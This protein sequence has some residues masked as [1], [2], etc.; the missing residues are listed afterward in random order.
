MLQLHLKV[1]KSTKYLIIIIAINATAIFSFHH[2]IIIS[3]RASPATPKSIIC[4]S[5]LTHHRFQLQARNKPKEEHQMNINYDQNPPVMDSLSLHDVSSNLAEMNQDQKNDEDDDSVEFITVKS[6]SKSYTTVTK[7]NGNTQHV[8]SK[9]I[10][11]NQLMLLL[12]GIP[13]SGKST[14]ADKLVAANPNKFVRINQD[15]LKTRK[16]CE[17]KCR[18]ALRNGKTVIID[19][20]NFDVE[21]RKF[22]IDIASEFSGCLVDCIFFDYGIEV[23]IDRCDRREHHETLTGAKLI[24]DVVPR[25]HSLLAPPNANAN[26][27]TFRKITVVNSFDQAD[28][29]VLLY[30][31]GENLS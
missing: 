2:T 31:Q 24:R 30:A 11:T 6:I 28:K 16:K 20:V 12:V 19:R 5:I 9:G 25:M 13:G 29:V 8:T 23:C 3:Q 4:S 21:Q 10:N 26:I 27:E 18:H 1:A 22:F 7:Q 17:S 14:F 15:K